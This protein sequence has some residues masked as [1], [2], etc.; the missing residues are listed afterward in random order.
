MAADFI[1]R[2]VGFKLPLEEIWNPFFN[3]AFNV[4]LNHYTNNAPAV[5]WRLLPLGRIPSDGSKWKEVTIQAKVRFICPVC[6]HSWTSKRGIAEFWWTVAPHCREGEREEGF[7][8]FELVGQSCSNCA[9]IYLS[10]NCSSPCVKQPA[11]WYD[12]QVVE[13]I[14]KLMTVVAEDYG[15]WT[16]VP[17]LTEYCQ[18]YCVKFK[19]RQQALKRQSETLYTSTDLD[20]QRHLEDWSRSND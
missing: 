9:S 3:I 19:P 8:V 6:W 1:A 15:L 7:V 16:R 18:M 4:C 5:I 20:R 14:W 11:L 17:T 2:K 10:G 13:T 12:D